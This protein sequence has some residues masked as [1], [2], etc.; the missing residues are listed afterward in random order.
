[1]GSLRLQR[2]LAQRFERLGLAA[3]APCHFRNGSYCARE[4]ESAP[5]EQRALNQLARECLLACSSD[6]PFIMTMGTM[7]PYAVR[8]AFTS[9]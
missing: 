1:M 9:T 4:R 6:W 8:A 3:P 2:Y 5:L 7:A